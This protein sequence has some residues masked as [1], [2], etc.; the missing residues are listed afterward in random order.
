VVEQRSPYPD[1]DGRD[2]EPATRHVL[3]EDR[4]TLVGCLRLLEDGDRM[5]IGRVAVAS[6]ARGT[7]LARRLMQTAMT[8][9][10]GREVRLDAQT[11]LVAFYEG[12]GF[13]VTGPEFDE[14]GV[15]H[16]PMARAATPG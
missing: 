13:E 7:G 6:A 15:R 1:L 8:L 16:V 10:A 14:D 5:R 3:A 11:G 2:L 4:G 12:F 9:C